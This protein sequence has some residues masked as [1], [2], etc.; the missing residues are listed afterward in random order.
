MT[1]ATMRLRVD[2]TLDGIHGPLFPLPATRQ[3]IADA[4]GWSETGHH[5]DRID[6]AMALLLRGKAVRLRGAIGYAEFQP[7]AD[8]EDGRSIPASAGSIQ[9]VA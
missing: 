9:D 8:N 4:M 7:L 1:T 2:G 3:A 6:R 5:S